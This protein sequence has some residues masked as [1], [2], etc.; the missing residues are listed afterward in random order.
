MDLA[1]NNLN[2]LHT[3]AK[4]KSKIYEIS[5]IR[6]DVTD[7]D[8]QKALDY[9]ML[10][11]LC[12]FGML[13]LES[14]GIL[15]TFPDHQRKNAFLSHLISGKLSSEDKERLTELLYSYLSKYTK[16]VLNVPVPLTKNDFSIIP[17]YSDELYSL[18]VRILR[19]PENFQNH[20]SIS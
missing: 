2:P 20:T 15:Y 3:A 9:L 1:W 11:T 19:K 7:R 14:T 6:N 18:I 5:V 13:L 4:I 17:P 10:D 8:I 16:N 12:A